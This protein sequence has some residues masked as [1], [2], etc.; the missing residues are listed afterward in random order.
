MQLEAR[1]CLEMGAKFCKLSS[2]LLSIYSL[3]DSVPRTGGYKNEQSKCSLYSLGGW[4]G[5]VSREVEEELTREKAVAE[6][7]W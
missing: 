1:Q 6:T 2:F 7:V 4:V 5:G 3:S